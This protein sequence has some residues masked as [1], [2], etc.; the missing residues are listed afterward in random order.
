MASS[1]I[2]IMHQYATGSECWLVLNFLALHN[3]IMI[4]KGVV[5]DTVDGEYIEPD[6]DDY[7]GH[8]EEANQESAEDEQVVYDMVISRAIITRACDIT[9][10]YFNVA[11]SKLE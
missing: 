2:E 10:H 3:V 5:G 11:A 9:M 4:P 8:L 1:G 6:T 7:I